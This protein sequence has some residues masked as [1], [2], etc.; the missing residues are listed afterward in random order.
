MHRVE[1]LPRLPGHFFSDP[2]PDPVVVNF[3]TL[4]QS[5][6]ISLDVFSMLNFMTTF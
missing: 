5:R 2:S 6:P 3:T 4:T 1:L